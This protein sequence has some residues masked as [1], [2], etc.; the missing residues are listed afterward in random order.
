MMNNMNL[1]FISFILFSLD[2]LLVSRFAVNVSVL[3]LQ[4]QSSMKIFVIFI[5]IL[6]RG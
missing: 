4:D 2:L 6:K 1:L 5:I 3:F